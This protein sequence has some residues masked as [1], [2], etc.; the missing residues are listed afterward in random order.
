MTSANIVGGL[1]VGKVLDLTQHEIE[2]LRM[3][4]NLADAHTHQSQSPTQRGIVENVP[5]LW[6]EAE[7]G[8]QADFEERCVHAFFTLHGQPTATAKSKVLL[9]YAASISVMVAA[10]CSPT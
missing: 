9:T 8:R 7:Q 5:K 1:R 3:G 4:F 10:M 2:D 6:Y